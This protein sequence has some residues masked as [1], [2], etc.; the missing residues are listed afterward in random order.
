[1]L[2]NVEK[3]KDEFKDSNSQLKH[4]IYDLKSFMCALKD[5]Y[6]VAIELRLL[7]IKLRISFC[8]WLTYNTS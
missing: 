4:C 6:L 7:K 8:D 5:P 1:M 2:D 3:E